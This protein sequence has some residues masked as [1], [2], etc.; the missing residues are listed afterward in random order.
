MR[1]LA[2]HTNAEL[3]W[4]WSKSLKFCA[5]TPMSPRRYQ[6]PENSST[7]TGA[8][9]RGACMIGPRSAAPADVKA[10]ASA[11]PANSATFRLRMTPSSTSRWTDGRGRTDERWEGLSQPIFKPRLTLKLNPDFSLADFAA[12]CALL[13]VCRAEA[14]RMLTRCVRR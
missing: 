14:H 12:A 6:P 8:I 5:P 3:V 13:R 1:Q 11:A 9:G 4:W 7:C 2:G 10:A